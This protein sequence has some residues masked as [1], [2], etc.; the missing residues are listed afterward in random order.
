MNKGS[1][2]RAAIHS[3][4]P[5]RISSLAGQFLG[6][7]WLITETAFLLMKFDFVVF[8]SFPFVTLRISLLRYSIRNH[9]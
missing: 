5:W 4:T 6:F 8:I 3:G 9:S 2:D 1:C 7:K